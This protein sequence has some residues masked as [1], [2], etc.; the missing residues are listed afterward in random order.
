MSNDAES[1]AA[2]LD[3]SDIPLKTSL[4]LLSSLLLAGCAAFPHIPALPATPTA[5]GPLGETHPL[6]PQIQKIITL[7]ERE[8]RFFGEQRVLI[9]GDVESIPRVG[10]WED[11]EEQHTMRIN[12][13]WRTVEES[14]ISGKD[15]QQPWSAVFLSWIMKSAGVAEA[16][17]PPAIAHWMY[18][19]RFLA[20]A[21]HPEAG[22][23]PH[24][25]REYAPQPG[26]L[27]CASRENPPA[28]PYLKIPQ[29]EWVEHTRMHCDL[30]VVRNG[31][32]LEAIGGNV[33]NSV[34]RTV[35]SLDAKGLLSPS[36]PRPWFLI[37]ENRL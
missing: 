28:T 2:N 8:W 16:R 11:D 29:P 15:C 22:F 18:V 19:S 20:E 32:I 23:L 5:F 21:G 14:E 35:L 25:L 17:F 9:D 13:Y 3:P 31:R 37:L 34:S 7:A 24:T 26:D 33:R 36:R 27:I 10:I 30:V 6:S 12:W 4:S 1:L